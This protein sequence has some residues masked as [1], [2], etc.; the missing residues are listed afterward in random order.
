VYLKYLQEK[1]EKE[2]VKK[3]A[4]EE[5]KAEVCVGF[6]D[7]VHS[8]VTCEARISDQFPGWP[9]SILKWKLLF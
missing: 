6:M 3:E 9:T 8:D 5:E 4:N 1:K 7:S 2:V